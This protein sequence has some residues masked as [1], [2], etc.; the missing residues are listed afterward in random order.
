VTIR[1][2]IDLGMPMIILF[3]IKV[4]PPTFDGV[5]NPKV[6]SAWLADM[7]DY[8]DWF[9]ISEERKVR[10]ARMQLTGSARVYWA[11]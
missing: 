4:D 10:L 5:H 1:V 8:F 7:N 2:P 9:R 11:S 6:F 3:E